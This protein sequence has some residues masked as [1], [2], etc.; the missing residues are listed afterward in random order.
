MPD[1]KAEMVERYLG[2]VFKKKVRLLSMQVL[3][4]EKEAV[5]LKGFGYG[6]PLMLEIE[7]DGE[8]RSVVLESMSAGQFGHEHFSDRAQAM[9]WD[10]DTFNRLPRHARAMDAGAFTKDGGLA[11]AGGAEEFFLL[12]D[13]IKGEG[14][15]KDLE[16]I[17]ES[18]R[19]TELDIN[20]ALA[21]SDYLVEIHKIKKE[22]PTLY[23]RKIR[24]TIGHGEC[25][26][27][28]IDSYPEK[29]EFIN[30]RLL[31]GIEKR[32]VEWRWRIKSLTHRL[33]QVHGDF[34]PWNILFRKGADFTVL[35]R[36]RGE[37][38]EPADD[39]TAITINYIFFSLQKYGRLEGPFKK[40]FT[41]F[42]ENYLKKTGDK[43]V[44]S[45]VQPFYAFRGLV[46]ASPIWYP[47]LKLDVRKK[48]FRFIERV[49][50]SKRFN[51]KDVSKYL[52]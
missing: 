46:I 29:F 4:K 43:E 49:L 42:W 41:L 8:R 40:L 13:F 48:V 3:G 25:I 31:E 23:I 10:Y 28:I 6:V 20:R 7:L 39:I 45:V 36:A 38:G 34:H 32:C 22:E 26:M 12:M 27:G 47:R 24:D 1:V 14:Y 19:L 37:W 17:K 11:S 52:I 35:D 5:E 33:S 44:L 30:K 21:L 16:R 15:F 51:Y 2:A 18:E 9:L 50:A